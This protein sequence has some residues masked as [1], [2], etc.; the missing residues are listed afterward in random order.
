MEAVRK[1]FQKCAG[2]PFLC[3]KNRDNWKADLDFL[4]DPSKYANIIEGKYDAWRNTNERNGA[5]G[6]YSGKAKELGINY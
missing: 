2:T 1:Y 5:C 4:L 3:G 6:R